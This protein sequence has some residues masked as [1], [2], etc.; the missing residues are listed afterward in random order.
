MATFLDVAGPTGAPAIILHPEQELPKVWHL[1]S[2]WEHDGLRGAWQERDFDD[3][4]NSISPSPRSCTATRPG[5][6]AQ[7]PEDRVDR[8]ARRAHYGPAMRRPA[9]RDGR[10]SGLPRRDQSRRAAPKPLPLAEAHRRELV[11]RARSPSS[12]RHGDARALHDRAD[13]EHLLPRHPRPGEGRGGPDERDTL[14]LVT[15]H[16]EWTRIGRG[17]LYHRI[18]G[19]DAQ[20][21]P[22]VLGIGFGR[23]RVEAIMA[24]RRRTDPGS[25]RLWDEPQAESQFEQ[26]WAPEEPSSE[27][28]CAGCVREGTPRRGQH[29][30]LHEADPIAY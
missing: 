27:T 2:T 24:C 5:S 7:A 15:R 23:T 10:V 22:T 13:D 14:R 3:G 21:P 30:T 28:R 20:K 17:R 8:L 9:V 18:A 19:F 29:A 6:T 4:G 26:T 16:G 11:A 12:R 1:R 25:L